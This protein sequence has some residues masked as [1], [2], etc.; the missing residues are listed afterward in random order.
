[1]GPSKYLYHI[2]VPRTPGFAQLVSNTWPDRKCPILGQL[3]RSPMT[4]TKES[5]PF[6]TALQMPG[7]MWQSYHKHRV[8]LL[9]KLSLIHI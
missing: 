3:D 9:L 5:F 8:L 1:M 7:S 4:G 6:R 2:I